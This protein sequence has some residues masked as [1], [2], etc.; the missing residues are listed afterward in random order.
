MY[1]LAI[2]NIGQLCISIRLV[3][4]FYSIQ[5]SINIIDYY[6]EQIF[7]VFFGMINNFKQF[8]N[9]TILG[10]VMYEYLILSYF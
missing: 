5:D 10:F 3:V 6:S 2:M 8:Y 9:T 4:Y 7:V 1:L